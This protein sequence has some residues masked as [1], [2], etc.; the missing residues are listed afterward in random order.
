MIVHRAPRKLYRTDVNSVP[1]PR[2]N[3][4]NCRT[5]FLILLRFFCENYGDIAMT[6]FPNSLEPSIHGLLSKDI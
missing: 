2:L 4:G 6:F 1:Q 5:V 3:W